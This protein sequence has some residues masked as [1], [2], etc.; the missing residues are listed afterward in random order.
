MCLAARK[1]DESWRW[2]ERYGHLSFEA[3]HQLGKQE[4]VRGTPVIKHA[5]QVCDTCVTTK[6]RRKPFP[7]QAQYR[8]QVP[9]DLVHGDLCGPVTPATPGGRRY[10]LL[11]VDD[12]TRFMWAVLLPTKDAALDAVK[13]VK[14]EAEKETGRELKVLQTDNGGEFTVGELA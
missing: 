11:M 6:L 13:R 8:A 4:M 5:E 1:E 7:Q 9:L 12:A 14:A 3:L 2:H 10:F